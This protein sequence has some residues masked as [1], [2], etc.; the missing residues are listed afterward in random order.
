MFDSA[1]GLDFAFQ[2]PEERFFVLIRPYLHNLDCDEP[3]SVYV[4]STEHLHSVLVYST[5]SGAAC[6]LA[7]DMGLLTFPNAP[8]PI[9]STLA[10]LIIGLLGNAE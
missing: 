10:H 8:D 3:T 1:N 2:E 7:G 5:T 4:D 9:N 6:H